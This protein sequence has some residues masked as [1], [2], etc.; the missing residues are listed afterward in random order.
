MNG[1][2]PI[3]RARATKLSAFELRFWRQ[4]SRPIRN[5][6]QLACCIDR[7]ERD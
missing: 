3:K 5:G 7:H 6:R 4:S 2:S 1:D